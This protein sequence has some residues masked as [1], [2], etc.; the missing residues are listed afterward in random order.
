MKTTA[1]LLAAGQGTRMKS[2]LPKVLHPVAG[3]P[4]VLRGL[5]LARAASGE[6]P[7][8]VIGHGAEQ[9]RAAVGAA[10]RCVVQ[11]PRGLRLELFNAPPQSF[12]DG[13]MI[14]GINEHL[15][16]VEAV[17]HARKMVKEKI[18]P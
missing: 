6:P 3:Q 4:M 7:V 11:Q 18:S 17:S 5:E 15:F 10:A 9:V 12:V 8:V 13:K 2:D 1:V 14:R 16:A